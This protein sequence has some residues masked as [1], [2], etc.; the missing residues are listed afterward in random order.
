MPTTSYIFIKIQIKNKSIISISDTRLSCCYH[1][2]KIIMEHCPTL[3]EV[4]NEEILVTKMWP[5]LMVKFT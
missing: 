5:R 1:S 4:L 2:C 3:I